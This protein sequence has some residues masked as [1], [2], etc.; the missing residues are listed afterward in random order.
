MPDLFLILLFVHV[1]GA[2]IAFGPT[3]AFPLMG[4]MAGR[5][6]QHGNYT[7]RM[8]ALLGDRL[9]EPMVILTGISGIAMIW[10]RNLPLLE[11]SYRWLLLSLVLYVGAMAFSLLVQRPTVHKMIELTSGPGAPG[12]EFGP[13]AGRASRNGRILTVLTVVVVYLMVVK[14]SLGF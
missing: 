4:S 5:E 2:I 7:T 1:L 6:P 13:T 14:P 3:F 9:V 8:S 12:P 11:A 10:W